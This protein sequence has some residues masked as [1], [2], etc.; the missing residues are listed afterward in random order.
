MNKDKRNKR[1]C[2]RTTGIHNQ[3]DSLQSRWKTYHTSPNGAGK[4]CCC[5]IKREVW[6]KCKICATG[7]VSVGNTDT[8]LFDGWCKV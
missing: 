2:F 4:K 8:G 5:H 3:G 7:D 1:H 6:E